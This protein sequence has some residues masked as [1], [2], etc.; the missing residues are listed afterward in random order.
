VRITQADTSRFPKVT[1]YVSVTDAAGEPLPVDPVSIRLRENGK[2]VEASVVGAVGQ[3]QPLTTLLLID[4][5]GSMAKAGKL[6][7]AKSAAKA[8]IG[9]MRPNDQ[10][11]VMA[12]NTQVQS[13]QPVT[14]DHTALTNAIDGL[15]AGGD[16]AMYDALYAAVGEL[17]PG[18]GRKAIIV[19]TDGMDNRS[20]RTVQGVIQRVGP[21]RL[22]ISVIGL[23]DPTQVGKGLEG[24]DENALQSLAD[25]AGGA[26]AYA[27]APDALNSI[28][29]RYGRVLSSEYS[30]EYTSAEPLRDGVNRSLSVDLAGVSGTASG[31]GR[32]NPGGLVPEVAK[33]APWGLFLGLLA[34]LLALL[35]APGLIR[36]GLQVA[37]ARR[38]A[39]PEAHRK[40][41]VR[42][43][44]QP[45]PRVR[46]H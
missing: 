9:Q 28:Y 24:L 11:G 13:I 35:V 4:V 14:Q 8:Y 30:F 21:G 34:A 38:A 42:L 46:L 32:Y 6:D 41:G 29:E 45:S 2:P 31:Q 27:S 37:Q 3:G 15:K 12:F 43:H 33:A 1:V 18:Q 10:A 22:T 19:L 5:S 17:E 23:G 36:R 20:Q 16:T 44:D 40:P 7:G 26:Y 25:G 39:E